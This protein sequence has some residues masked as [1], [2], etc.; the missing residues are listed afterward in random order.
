MRSLL[1]VS[2]HFP[3]INAPDHQRVRMALGHFEEFGWK[4]TTLAVH[5]DEVEGVRDE[6]LERTLPAGAEV[7]RTSAWPVRC[8]R[9]FGLG[10]LAIRA[11]RQLGKAGT[12]LL[13]KRRFDAIFFSTTQFPTMALGRK[14]LKR[15]GTP[16]VLDFQDPWLSDYY[17]QNGLRPPGG[18]FKYRLA[19][20]QAK[21]LEPYACRRAARIVSVSSAYV[22][23]LRKR[24]PEL[25]SEQ[26]TVLPFG[27]AD[28]DFDA[29]REQH[30][31]QN[32]FNS[33]DGKIHWVYVG[34][35]GNDM[36]LALRSLLSA[37]VRY[38]EKVPGSRAKLRLHF[39]G[40]SYA[41]EGRA[42]KTVEPLAREFGLGDIVEEVTGRL[43]YFE[44]LQ[45]LLDAN[46]LIVTGSDDPGYTASK[47][48]PYILARKPMLAIFHESSSVVDVL[49][50]TKAGTVIPFKTGESHETIA[51]QILESRWFNSALESTESIAP[52]VDWTAFE[53]YTAREMTRKLCGVFDKVADGK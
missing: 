12:E 25:S 40:T 52:T 30:I 8:T 53:P 19:K 4:A 39:I 48:Y 15:F 50:K 23:M 47:I 43:P 17:E 1:I 13:S 28:K 7:I 27:A 35:G 42:Q 26:F 18:H 33:K 16:Y 11:Y 34:R 20:L 10:S 3:P 24:Y 32:I 9:A 49:T 37:L 38:F 14:W 44:A 46:A 51:L 45:C 22:S 6:T 36:A 29:L 2:P 31:R 21:W 5:P 41:P